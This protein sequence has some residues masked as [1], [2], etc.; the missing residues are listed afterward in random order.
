[1]IT[2]IWVLCTWSLITT[3]FSFINWV[4][5]LWPWK[6][7]C[8]VHDH[9]NWGI[10]S[11][12]GPLKTESYA[13][14]MKSA[15]RLYDHFKFFIFT[16]SLKFEYIRT[17]PIEFLDC[18]HNYFQVKILPSAHWK[19]GIAENAFK[20]SIFC[21]IPIWRV[22]YKF[23]ISQIEYFLC[24]RLLFHWMPRLILHSKN[25][26]LALYVSNKAT[27]SVLFIP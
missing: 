17:V 8:C 12:A 20:I 5:Y 1:M 16:W 2:D 18:A 27:Y 24:D 11:V 25:L 3:I 7:E 6:F 14:P 10:L 26:K 22:F 19:Q 15:Y 9:Q 23:D 4:W 13:W 21:I